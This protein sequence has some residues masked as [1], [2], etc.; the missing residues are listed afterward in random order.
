MWAKANA[1]VIL[2]RNVN[3]RDLEFHKVDGKYLNLKETGW[4][5]TDFIVLVQDRDK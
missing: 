4:N 2:F 3:G 1:D 5:D